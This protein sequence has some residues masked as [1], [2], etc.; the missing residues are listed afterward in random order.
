MGET[1]ALLGIWE[2][3]GE[4]KKVVMA[5]QT[6]AAVMGAAA[7]NGD[8]EGIKAALGELGKSCGG[9]HKVFHKKK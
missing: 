5:F 7:D 8:V 4:F 1:E 3:P 2:N 6:A 9:C